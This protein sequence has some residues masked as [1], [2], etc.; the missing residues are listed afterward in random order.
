MTTNKV[1]RKF[2]P[3][4]SVKLKTIPEAKILKLCFGSSKRS[5]FPADKLQFSKTLDIALQLSPLNSAFAI[6]TAINNNKV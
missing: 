1:S 3:V 5:E 6:A 4:V 2:L